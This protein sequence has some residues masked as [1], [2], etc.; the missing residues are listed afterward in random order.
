MENKPFKPFFNSFEIDQSVLN[1]A[2]TPREGETISIGDKQY[3]C[4]C[5]IMDEYVLKEVESTCRAG[6]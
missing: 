5:Q 2:T 4:I 1:L 3:I 6:A